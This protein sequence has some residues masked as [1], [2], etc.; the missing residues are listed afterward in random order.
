MIFSNDN[1]IMSQCHFK[2]TQLILVEQ[3][4]WKLKTVAENTTG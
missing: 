2:D 3:S 1:A 4:F